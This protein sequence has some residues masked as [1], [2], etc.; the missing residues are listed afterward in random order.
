[1]IQKDQV[2]VI[3]VVVTDLTQETM[4]LNVISQLTN[5]IAKF[6][7]IAK[8]CKYRGFHEG[9]HFISM[10]MNMHGAL[11]CDM[12]CFIREC[13]CLFHDKQSRGHLSFFFAFN[14]SSSMLVLFFS[15]F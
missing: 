14:F 7:A 3:D 11:G 12:D 2:F 6:N 15:M 13:A 8:I 5:A 4:T 9:H 1:M 10:G